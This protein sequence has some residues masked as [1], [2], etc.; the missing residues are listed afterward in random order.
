MK[1]TTILGSLLAMGAA[2][3]VSAG[4]V[5]G[6]IKGLLKARDNHLTVQSGDGPKFTHAGFVSIPNHL[7]IQKKIPLLTLTLLNL[8][9]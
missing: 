6:S 4:P 7:G 2:S 5:A 3:T 8:V 1:L 9:V